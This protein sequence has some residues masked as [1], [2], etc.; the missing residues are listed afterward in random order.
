[1]VAFEKYLFVVLTEL[2]NQRGALVLSL[3][4]PLGIE[5]GRGSKKK[6]NYLTSK[7]VTVKLARKG[8]FLSK[9]A[10][11]LRGGHAVS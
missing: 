9:D 5:K 2:R 8:D 3:P 11:A 4:D 6:K 7:S 1:V 10:D